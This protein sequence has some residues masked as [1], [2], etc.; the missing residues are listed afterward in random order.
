VHSRFGYKVDKEGYT[1]LEPETE[2]S[3]GIFATDLM[4]WSKLL[5][6]HDKTQAMTKEELCG[7]YLE[8]AT[9]VSLAVIA[10]HKDEKWHSYGIQH[11][12]PVDRCSPPTF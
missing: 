10:A 3:M 2:N 6:T 9:D 1:E 11:L 8:N 4:E 5:R 7:E 12:D